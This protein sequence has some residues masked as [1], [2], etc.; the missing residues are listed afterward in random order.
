MDFCIDNDDTVIPETADFERFDYNGEEDFAA[1]AGG[2]AFARPTASAAEMAQAILAPS[3]RGRSKEAMPAA[4]GARY[5]FV[6]RSYTDDHDAFAVIEWTNCSAANLWAILT[7]QHLV[8]G[9]A[10]SMAFMLTFA[11]KNQLYGNLK[12][13]LGNRVESIKAHISDR[14]IKVTPELERL[15]MDCC[16][17]PGLL[18]SLASALANY[19]I[20]QNH[21]VKFKPGV[22]P[23]AS[24]V[25]QWCAR[26]A[27][28][29][30]E[31][32]LQEFFHSMCNANSER[33]AVHEPSL[34]IASSKQRIIERITN[35]Y[36]N[37]ANF[38]PQANPTIAEWCDADFDSSVVGKE[39][40]T[41]IWV[42]TKIQ[43]IKTSMT[44]LMSNF[45]KSGD[46]LNDADH[47]ARD[48]EFFDKFAKRDAL[49]FWIYLCW[50][51]GRNIPVWNVTSLPEGE[52]FDLGV[53]GGPGQDSRDEIAVVSSSKSSKKRGRNE[54]DDALA[55]TVSG[56]VDV[57]R[58]ALDAIISSQATATVAHHHYPP[59]SPANSQSQ[60]STIALSPEKKRAEDL[61]A[62][63]EQLSQ[64]V[65]IRKMLPDTMQGPVDACISKVTRQVHELVCLNVDDLTA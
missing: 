63:K 2:R 22:F 8:V 5:P 17:I 7:S 40:R 21:V 43:A 9:A 10:K 24:E 1:A 37:N 32:S 33:L 60:P 61:T 39:P 26:L 52:S 20:I 13:F 62:F 56:L 30:V 28:C 15:F 48:L 59:H 12:H 31:P 35:D 53:S 45:H 49:W 36:V 27:A 58:R 18:P 51:H 57:S 34:R 50:D 14:G 4:Y 54:G 44:R 55:S 25:Q 6:F 64:L 41:W 38:I 29:M 42:A 3:S 65:E 46:L 11:I 47:V 16:E 19:N 23:E